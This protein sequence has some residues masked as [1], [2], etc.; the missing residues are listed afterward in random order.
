MKVDMRGGIDVASMDYPYLHEQATRRDTNVATL[1]RELV[2]V[3][4]R[5]KMVDS[6]LDD[7]GKPLGMPGSVRPFYTSQISF[8]DRKKRIMSML[9]EKGEVCVQDFGDDSSYRNTLVQM[10]DSGEITR[11][12]RTGGRAS[13]QF[14][15]LPSREQES[16]GVTTSHD[17][18]TAREVPARAAPGRISSTFTMEGPVRR[19]SRPLPQTKGDL[20]RMLAEAAANTARMQEGTD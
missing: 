15:R 13:R 7:D 18:S 17:A 4:A 1:V 19:P 12:P 3:I 14:Y 6:V 5:E 8:N 16:S 20:R 9:H 11:M 2:R 10:A